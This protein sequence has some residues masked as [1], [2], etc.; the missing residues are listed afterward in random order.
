MT[1]LQSCRG[2]YMQRSTIDA[3]HFHP[4]ATCCAA[5][6]LL[7][8]MQTCQ[9]GLIAH[10]TRCD[11]TKQDGW[12]SVADASRHLTCVRTQKRQ[13]SSLWSAGFDQARNAVLQ[14]TPVMGLEYLKRLEI[15]L[16]ACMH[17]VFAGN[18]AMCKH[19]GL[20]EVVIACCCW[21]H[22]HCQSVMAQHGIHY[23]PPS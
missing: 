8:Q 16:A 17:E 6:V 3:E 18:T 13:A 20:S 1:L 12:H 2:M 21:C 5:C 10:E 9:S 4:Y 7:H 15:H 11:A 19:A 23:A 22:A 14:G